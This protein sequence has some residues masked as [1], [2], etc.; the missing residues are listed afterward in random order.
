MLVDEVAIRKIVDAAELCRGETVL[1]VGAGTGALAKEALQRV[2]PNGKVVAVELQPGPARRLRS[3]NREGLHV[4]QGDAMHVVLPFADAVVTNPPFR[5]MAPLLFRL[6]DAGFGRAVS[7]VPSEFAR[8]VSA[9][10]GSD[11]YGRLTVAAALRCEART[12]FHLHR[13]VFDPPPQV[14]CV[15]TRIEPRPTVGLDTA[16]LGQVLAMAWESKDRTMRHGLGRLGTELRISSARVTQVLRDLGLEAKT[17]K[18]TSP[19]EFA[20]LV[21]ALAPG[22]ASPRR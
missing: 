16:L 8:R 12:L 7:V 19:E 9:K 13:W 22:T 6:L 5:I 4:I 15:V 11:D 10:P 20:S 14:A 18:E 1:D 17:P 21:R 3:E 2:K